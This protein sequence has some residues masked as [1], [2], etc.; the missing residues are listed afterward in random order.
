MQPRPHATKRMLDG[1]AEPFQWDPTITQGCVVELLNLALG[2]YQTEG[3][4]EK[5]KVLVAQS[6]LTL[7][8][9]ME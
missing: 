3:K 9:P 2:W 7:C 4:K 8:D 6:P 1:C 5:A